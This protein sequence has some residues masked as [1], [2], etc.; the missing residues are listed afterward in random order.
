MRKVFHVQNS[1]LIMHVIQA[2]NEI[3]IIW[4]TKKVMNLFLQAAN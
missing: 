2:P 1:F 4:N 3:T